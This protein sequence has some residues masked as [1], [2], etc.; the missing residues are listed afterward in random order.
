MEK[1]FTSRKAL[2]AMDAA[3]EQAKKKLEILLVL[4]IGL[5]LA[6]YAE[7]LH[8]EKCFLMLISPSSRLLLMD[9]SPSDYATIQSFEGGKKDGE[10]L[11][12]K[13]RELKFSLIGN[14][15]IAEMFF[16][17]LRKGN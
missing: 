1:F 16:F 17:L 13:K 7:I 4:I 5:C 6:S 9:S 12:R 8:V 14:E 11:H 10:M 3:A 2:A 15:A